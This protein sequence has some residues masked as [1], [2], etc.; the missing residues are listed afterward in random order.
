MARVIDVRP[1]EIP[2]DLDEVRLLFR[3]YAGSLAFDLGFQDFEAELASL[4]GKYAP[5]KGRLLVA[6]NGGDA[7]GCV[8]L[9]PIDRDACEMKR[10]FVRP[11]ARGLAVGRVLA[12]RIC[13]EARAAGYARICLD[14]VPSMTAAIALYR[15]LGF[16]ETAPYVFNP[17]AG[18]IFLA[19]DTQ[20]R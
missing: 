5:P 3:E 18:A 16:R 20:P 8:A 4:P 17:I 9:R 2:R 1:A 7:V 10:L 6:W 11:G 12:E 15:S 13:D 19:R 14:T